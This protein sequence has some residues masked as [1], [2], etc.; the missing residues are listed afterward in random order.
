MRGR[1]ARWLAVVAALAPAAGRAQPPA[2]ASSAANDTTAAPLAGSTADSPTLAPSPRGA[3]GERTRERLRMVERQIAHPPDTRRPVEDP[4]VLQAMRAVPRHA[5]VPKSRGWQAYDDSPLPIGEGQ[6]ISQPY[7]VALMTEL[8]MLRPGDRVL[9]VGTGSGYQAAVLAELTP[10]V[11]TI[12][13]VPQ[14]H[15]RARRLLADLG[16]GTVRTRLGDGFDG[17]PQYAPYQGILMTCAIDEVPAPLWD[18]LA[19]GGRMVLPLGDMASAQELVVLI[20]G[21][22]GQR[23]MQRILP[24]R[25]VPTTGKAQT[26]D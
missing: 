3:A 13:I 10:H 15:E 14:L 20:K 11:F 21:D 4:R 7:I 23:Q 8:L 6:T 19:V 16:Y 24:V 12:E 5:F 25:F 22:D 26:P 17:W 9:E 1:I 2:P 18:Q